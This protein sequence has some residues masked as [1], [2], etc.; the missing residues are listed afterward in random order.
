MNKWN[1]LSVMMYNQVVSQ[2]GLPG[3]NPNSLH[4]D[5]G[6]FRILVFSD[7]IHR[8]EKKFLTQ[9]TYLAR[10]NRSMIMCVETKI[11]H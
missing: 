2:I 11:S 8:G 3:K 4:S 6:K 1:M 9:M 7:T 10:R 5:H